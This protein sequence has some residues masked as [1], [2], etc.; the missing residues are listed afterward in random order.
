MEAVAGKRA[1]QEIRQE[2]ELI[3][4]IRSEIGQ[5][6]DLVRDVRELQNE[7]KQLEK[8]VEQLQKQ[9]SSARLDELINKARSI[10][11][12]IKLVAGEIENAD[13]DLLKQLGYESLEKNKKGTVTILGSRHEDEGKVYLAAAVT[14]DLIKGKGLKAGS[15]VG[16][17]GKMLG[18]GGGGQPSIATAGGRD[19]EKA[20][21]GFNQNLKLLVTSQPFEINFNRWFTSVIFL[22]FRYISLLSTIKNSC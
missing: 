19:T 11:D 12:D 9:Q 14:D 21:R 5:S 13:M 7:R 2:K 6:E 16:E 18:G 22:F 20:I 15:L 4:A 3:R 10:S 8:K 1:D 17:L